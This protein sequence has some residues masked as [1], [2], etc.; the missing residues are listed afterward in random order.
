MST[1]GGVNF[2]PTHYVDITNQIET[3]LEALKKHESQIKWMFEHDHID[4]IDMIRTCSRYRG[5][6][7]GVTY[8]EG[9][10]PCIVYP[11][12]TTKHLLP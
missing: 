5:Y 4:F 9:F 10:R 12:M 7:S 1:L 2:I 3:K 11:R 8:A 6:Q